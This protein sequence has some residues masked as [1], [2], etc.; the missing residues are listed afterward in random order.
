MRR[1]PVAT[2]AAQIGPAAARRRTWTPGHADHVN[3][4]TLRRRR[5]RSGNGGSSGSVIRTRVG[6]ASTAGAG[7]ARIAAAVSPHRPG[8]VSDRHRLTTL[9]QVAAA[10]S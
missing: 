6:T 1:A 2:A 9:A 5:R 7:S 10:C 4:T 8:Y 3:T